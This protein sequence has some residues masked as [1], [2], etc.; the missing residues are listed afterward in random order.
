MKR[1]PFLLAVALAAPL[2]L[3]PAS[4]AQTNTVRAISPGSF[5]AI[6]ISGS[7][8]VRFEQG[9]RDEVLYEGDDTA[10]DAPE[11]EVRNGTLLLHQGG[12][13]KF[14]NARKLHLLVKAR[15]LRRV[16]I[17]GAADFHAPTPV[18]TD[19]LAIDISGAGSARFDQLKADQL[20]FTVSGAGDGQMAGAVGMVNVQISGKSRFAGGRLASERAQ[21]TINGVGSVEVWAASHLDVSISGVGSVDYWGSPVVRRTVAG[22]GEINERGKR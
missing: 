11:L 15:A 21:V 5:D 3:A 2:L 19:T 16:S 8:V 20:N 22:R 4:Q 6:D 9:P 10:Q 14:W 18:K 1:R 17:A 12:A 13:W 7:A